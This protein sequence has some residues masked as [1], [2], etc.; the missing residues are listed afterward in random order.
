MSQLKQYV[1]KS[2]KILQEVDSRSWQE[3]LLASPHPDNEA[4]EAARLMKIATVY[5]RFTQEYPDLDSSSRYYTYLML[6]A[7]Y[8]LNDIP[9]R[10]RLSQKRFERL[11]E[12][13]DTT[14]MP[15]LPTD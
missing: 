2:L 5:L 6:R 1:A 14:P 4:G 8:L 10:G 13:C 9:T 11:I 12:I 7:M 3:M 15:Q